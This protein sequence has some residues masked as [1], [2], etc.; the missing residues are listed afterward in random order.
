MTPD[1]ERRVKASDVFKGTR[2]EAEIEAYLV[3]AKAN[4]EAIPEE[5]MARLRA[6]A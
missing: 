2:S 4:W 1:D 3:A 6:K 5:D